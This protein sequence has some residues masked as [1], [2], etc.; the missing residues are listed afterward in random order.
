M[1]IAESEYL[2]RGLMNDRTVL[3]DSSTSVHSS[4]QD[5][6][7]GSMP[8]QYKEG[9]KANVVHLRLAHVSVVQFHNYFLLTLYFTSIFTSNIHNFNAGIESI[10]VQGSTRSSA[11]TASGVWPRVFDFRSS[12]R[13]SVDVFKAGHM[14]RDPRH[15]LW[16]HTEN[17]TFQPEEIV[18]SS[19]WLSTIKIT[20]SIKG[21]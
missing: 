12:L 11:A 18:P 7:K 5:R 6:T 13:Y 1:W 17:R 2:T 8:R 10:P 21:E 20:I 4:W 14:H 9:V 19:L 16:L 15:R 3:E